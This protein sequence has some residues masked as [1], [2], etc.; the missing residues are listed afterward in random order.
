[1]SFGPVTGNV[2]VPELG[3]RG[4]GRR[5]VA[6]HLDLRDHGD[7]SGLGIGHNSLDLPLRVE[8]AVGPVVGTIVRLARNRRGGADGADGGKLGYLFIS[9]RQPWSS[10][11][12]KCEMLN[13]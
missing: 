11:K 9:I 3:V 4:D 1:M 10:V 2:L 6:G 12:R 13:L 8:A 5:G 7:E